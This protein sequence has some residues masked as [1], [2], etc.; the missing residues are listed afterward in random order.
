MHLCLV[1]HIRKLSNLHS[2][3]WYTRKIKAQLYTRY[4]TCIIQDTDSA[5][6]DRCSKIKQYQIRTNFNI[7]NKKIE[8]KQILVLFEPFNLINS[9]KIEKLLSKS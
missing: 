7:N 1:S 8:K 5:V 2:D 6:N 4:T 9:T 3:R